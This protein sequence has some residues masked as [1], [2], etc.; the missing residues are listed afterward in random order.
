M[1]DIVK[2]KEMTGAGMMDC[3][4]ALEESGGDLEKAAAVLREKG[5]AAAVKKQ[6][7]IA[8]EGACF[9]YVHLGGKIAVVVEI[10]CE[11]D[12]A[13]KSDAF[14]DLG[15]NIAMHIA[16]YSP[17][18]IN[19]SEVPVAELEQEKEILR[20]KALNEKKPSAVIEKMLEG[21]VKKYYAEISLLHQQYVVDPSKT[22]GDVVVETIAAIG[23][24]ISVRRFVRYEMGEGLEKKQENFAEEV[25]KVTAKK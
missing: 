16:A 21:Q 15:K 18:Y 13:A 4:K 24:K 19:E 23:E 7:R 8:A 3:K 2:L 20:N 12:F 1:S 25:A 14:Q 10:N 9:S 6:D 11:T 5:K 17:K 22:V